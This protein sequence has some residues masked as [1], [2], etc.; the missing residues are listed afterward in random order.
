MFAVIDIETTG[1]NPSAEKII[2][3]AILI[4]DGNKIIQEYSTLVNPEKTISPFIS[5]F[6]GITNHMVKDAPKF[7]EIA[8]TVLE[9]THGHIFVAHNVKFDYNFIK[10]EFKQIDIEYSRRTL[11]T[12][13]L[14]RKTFPQFRSHSLGNIC[15][16][17]G[18]SIDNR[19]RALGDAKATVELLKKIIAQYNDNF[20]E[21]VVQDDIKKLNLPPNLSP[22]AIENLSEEAGVIFFLNQQNDI[23]AVHAAKNI[24]EYL[25]KMYKEKSFDRYKK[26]LHQETHDISF[27]IT[28]NDLLANLLTENY[29]QKHIPRYNKVQK[30]YSFN[31]GMYIDIDEE[32]YYKLSVKVLDEE[33]EP[34]IKF[35]SKLK[36]ERML[37][38]ILNASRLGPIFKK[39]DSRFHYNQRLEE[40]LAKYKYPHQRFFIFLHGRSGQEKCAINILDG[41]LIG[42]T[43]FEPSYIQN[44]EELVDSLRPIQEY[45]NTKKDII[46]YIRKQEKYIQIVPY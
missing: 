33:E 19:H 16:D 46:T 15:R 4:F 6:T 45:S 30:H 11:D 13:L 10:H 5:T 34:I 37:N 18:I 17:L 32:G 8:Q 12:V 20:L 1:G 26:L 9:I 14:S 21:E 25:F 28:G 39:I 42:Y 22:K 2:E 38:Q 24:K 35:T 27:E 29:I 44:V 36:A 23:I 31:V 43:F 41:N 7:E 40:I 3:I